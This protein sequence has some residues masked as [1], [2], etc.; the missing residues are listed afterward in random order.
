MPDIVIS[1]QET[2]LTIIIITSTIITSTQKAPNHKY[3]VNIN[4]KLTIK[5]YAHNV[6]KRTFNSGTGIDRQFQFWNCLFKKKGIGID[7]FGMRIEVCYK[8]LN[9]QINLP[10]IFQFRNISSMTILLGI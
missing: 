3:H 6:L 4:L 5:V 2:K 9:L 1:L 7:K 8:K 10:F